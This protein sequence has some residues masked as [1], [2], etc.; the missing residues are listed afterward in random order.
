MTASGRLGALMPI[1]LSEDPMDASGAAPFRRHLFF[2]GFL[3]VAAALLFVTSGP[4]QVMSELTHTR[5]TSV[6]LCNCCCCCC[7]CRAAY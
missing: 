2:G 4:L 7:C 5:G 6:R 1:G 3:V